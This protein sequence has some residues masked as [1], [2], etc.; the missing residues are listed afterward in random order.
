MVVVFAI[1]PA[2]LGVHVFQSYCGGC[3]EVDVVT[4]II[5]TSHSHHHDCESCTC[6]VDCH[7]CCDTEESHSHDEGC[8]SCEHQFKK[9]DFEAQISF[10]HFVLNVVDID[11]LYASYVLNDELANAYLL[12]NKFSNVILNIPDEPSPEMNCVFLL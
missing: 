8:D 10:N 5:A 2:M 9:A 12:K 1:L 3:N 7:A 4:S 11:L 6:N